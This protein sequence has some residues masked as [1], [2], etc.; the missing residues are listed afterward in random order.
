MQD[1]NGG[2]IGKTRRPL[3]RKQ[4]ENRLEM[5]IGRFPLE[6]SGATTSEA[7]GAK[8]PQYTAIAAK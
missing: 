8:A 6:I 2:Y 4:A 1:G 7:A 5:S 3:L